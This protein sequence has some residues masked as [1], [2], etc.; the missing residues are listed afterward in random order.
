MGALKILLMP[1][2]I[3]V[4]MVTNGIEAFPQTLAHCEADAAM[5]VTSNAGLNLACPN[6]PC[7]KDAAELCAMM[8]GLPI[9]TTG[10]ELSLVLAKRHIVTPLPEAIVYGGRSVAPDPKPPRAL[11]T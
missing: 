9:S 8:G 3:F 6:S 5:Q 7:S 4:V 11:V 2:L 10:F 1:F